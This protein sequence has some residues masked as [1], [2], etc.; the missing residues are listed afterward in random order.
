MFEDMRPARYKVTKN[1]EVGRK[2]HARSDSGVAAVPFAF[3]ADS[4]EEL[5]T[6]IG[7]HFQPW[8]EDIRA[9]SVVVVAEGDREIAQITFPNPSDSRAE[10]V[11]E[12]K[13]S[14]GRT[15]TRAL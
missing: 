3:E 8:H 13:W 10:E 4:L 7:D 1:S 2:F 9:D 5:L 15:E 6:L 12:I 11:M 14:D